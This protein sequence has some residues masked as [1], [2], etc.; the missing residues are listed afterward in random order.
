MFF[1]PL[2]MKEDF[3]SHPLIWPSMGVSIEKSH[4]EYDKQSRI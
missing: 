4:E 3:H 2:S 1:L